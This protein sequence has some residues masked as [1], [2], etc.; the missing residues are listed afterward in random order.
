[1][2]AQTTRVALIVV[3]APFR[4]SR[5]APQR[6]VFRM[7]C[8]ARVHRHLRDPRAAA[9]SGAPLIRATAISNP[10]CRGGFETRPYKLPELCVVPG[11]QRIMTSEGPWSKSDTYDCGNGVNMHVI[12][13]AARTRIGW[14]TTR[15]ISA[16]TMK[17]IR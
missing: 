1:M 6:A 2:A 3:F 4:A 16:P 13:L 15:W 9:Q 17:P 10:R 11:L 7:R 14:I 12:C 5:A 8:S